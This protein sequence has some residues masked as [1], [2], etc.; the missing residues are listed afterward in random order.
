MREVRFVGTTCYIR[1]D[2]KV[3][4][5]K[6]FHAQTGIAFLR[7]AEKC[8]SAAQRQ[9][10]GETLVARNDHFSSIPSA[11]S[12]I[13]NVCKPNL[14]A[15]QGSVLTNDAHHPKTP[16]KSPRAQASSPKYASKFV[17]PKSETPED[18]VPRQD[19]LIAKNKTETLPP[20]D[21]VT[22]MYTAQDNPE[23]AE[24]Y[25]CSVLLSCYHDLNVNESVIGLTKVGYTVSWISFSGIFDWWVIFDRSILVY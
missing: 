14:S 8:Q 2:D 19:G 22:L 9:S 20:A 6:L 13:V 7:V 12:P 10:A 11:P 15:L 3:A 16:E 24:R 18:P 23:L 1:F 21:L 4:A 25:G 5:M 17:P